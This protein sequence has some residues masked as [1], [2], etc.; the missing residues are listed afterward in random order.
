MSKLDYRKTAH[1]FPAAHRISR[2]VI[3]LPHRQVKWSERWSACHL[4]AVVDSRIE[5]MRSWFWLTLYFI[6][7]AHKFSRKSQITRRNRQDLILVLHS[8]PSWDF[9]FALW[10]NSSKDRSKSLV[11]LRSW[12]LTNLAPL[13]CSVTWISMFRT[14]STQQHRKTAHRFPRLHTGKV[15]ISPK[16][17]NQPRTWTLRV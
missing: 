10:Y 7:P 15:A 13:P 14:R 8:L 9:T 6:R 12:P 5:I 4:N 17:R 1:R 3:V 2:P 11:V 16:L